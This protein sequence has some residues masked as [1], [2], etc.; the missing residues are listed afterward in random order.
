MKK[1][2]MSKRQK[3]NTIAG[4]LFIAPFLISFFV[5][6]LYP[7]VNS[8]YLSFTDYNILS[9][10]KWIGWD[11]YIK[12]FT[13]DPK[14]WN[15]LKVTFKFALI[16]VPLDLV[17]G[18]L[19][20][21]VLSIATKFTGIYRAFFY[22]P[23]LL[24]G[25]VAIAITWQQLWS[26]TG[27][28]NQMLE[29]MGLPAVNWLQDTRTALYILMLLGTWQFGRPMLI[30]L[31]AIKDVPKSLMEAAIIDGAS[32]VQRFFKITLPLITSTVFFNL[33]NGVIGSLQQYTS[34]LLITNGGPMQSTMFYGL[35][36]YKQAFEY[37][38]MGYAA[39]MAWV[40]M[41][42][43]LAL[44]ALVF[45]SSGGWVYYQDEL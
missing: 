10:S 16:S 26:K 40:I 24:G 11:N 34:A 5:F 29:S 15:A 31:A 25:T 13:N 9:G 42:I 19:V 20:A 23:S 28:I 38:H 8:L 6:T 44:T 32:S 35:Y 21:I 41:L 18:L 1:R 36:Q 37:H 7:F 33:V 12:I 4:Y 43:I 39:A 14:I 30:Y 27:V 3:R 45:K 22:V 17:V 2:H